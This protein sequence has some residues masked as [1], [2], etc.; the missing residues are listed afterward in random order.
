MVAGAAI[1]L[2]KDR[3]DALRRRENKNGT[4]MRPFTFVHTA[5]WQIGKVFGGFGVE[6][7]ARLRAARI[8]VIDRIADIAGEVGANDVLVAGDVFDREQ[9]SDDLLHRVLIKLAKHRDVQ[10]HLLPGNHDPVRA[11][12]VWERL[13]RLAPAPNV[14]PHLEPRPYQLAPRAQLLPAPLTARAA[15]EDPTLWFDHHERRADAFRI[16]LAHG[17]VWGFGSS[18]EASQRIAPERVVS[19]GLDY[20]ALGDWHGTKQIADRAWYSGTPEPDRYQ[21]NDPGNVLVVTLSEPGTPPR[22]EPRRTGHYRWLVRSL[23]ISSTAEI[24]A[25]VDALRR[26]VPDAES[27]VLLD[28]TVRGLVE[29]AEFGDVDAALTALAASVFDLDSDIRGLATAIDPT[30]LALFSDGGLRGVAEAL[31]SIRDTGGEE[32]P[33]ALKALQLLVGMNNEAQRSSGRKDAV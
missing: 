12:S 32:A 24:V 9:E 23:D 2:A 26:E 8:E 33:V 20:L 5:D 4:T 3:C 16:G 27:R 18:G 28:L 7:R 22:V 13:A 25:F 19:A 30:D 6:Q 17:S 10:W 31:M 14:V 11:G 29:L 15:T 21:D 1:F